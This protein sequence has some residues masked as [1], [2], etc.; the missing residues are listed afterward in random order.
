MTIMNQFNLGKIRHIFALS[1]LIIMIAGFSA[2]QKA[3]VT[4]LNENAESPVFAIVARHDYSQGN[5]SGRSPRQ[6]TDPIAQVAIANGGFSQLVDAMMYVDQELNAGLVNLFMNGTDQYTVFA[7]TDAAFNNLYTALNI[8]NIRALPASLVL[9][10]LQY[11]VT[12]GR[13]GS[14]SVVPRNGSRTIT[15]LL[16]NATFQVFPNLQIEAVGNT[17]NIIAADI[18]ASN[19]I[20]HVIDNVL[21]PI[22]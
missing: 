5:F 12:E 18:P 14:N 2:C 6:G 9:S 17:A 20:I 3:E 15:T 7:P 8:P 16:P 21:F 11:H 22:E 19:G 13:R 10:V 4:E 1:L